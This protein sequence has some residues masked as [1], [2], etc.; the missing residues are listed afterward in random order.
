MTSEILIDDMEFFALH[1]FY[2]EEQKIGCRYTV[3]L[4]INTSLELSGTTDNL[5]D[6]INYENVYQIVK[7]IMDNPVRL[8]EHVAALIMDAILSHYPQI[9]H[10]DIRLYKYNPPLGGQL[11]RVGIH[12]AK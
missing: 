7:H 10:L 6:T 2:P 12:L 3:S 9:E 1:G 4:I 5:N 11:N 8:I